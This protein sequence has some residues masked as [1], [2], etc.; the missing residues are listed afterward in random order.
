MT[1]TMNPAMNPT[2]DNRADATQ[3]KAEQ[4]ALNWNSLDQVHA[5]QATPDRD[6]PAPQIRP[7]QPL[8]WPEFWLIALTMVIILATRRLFDS[9]D[10]LFIMLLIGI[11]THALMREMRRQYWPLAL[12]MPATLVLSGWLCA[13]LVYD[14]TLFGGVLPTITTFKE[15]GADL[16]DS[17]FEF[18]FVVAPTEATDGFLLA[19]AIA[20]WAIAASA[21]SLAFRHKGTLSACVPV[22]VLMMFIGA[23]A[24]DGWAALSAGVALF[25]AVLF[26]VTHRLAHANVPW[27]RG[28]SPT[29][30]QAHAPVKLSL[31]LAAMAAVGAILLTPLLPGAQGEAL[32]ALKELDGGASAARVALNPL[33][34]ARGRLVSSSN[35][36][37][38]RVEAD[39]PAYWRV[40][41]LGTFDGF[42]WGSDRSYSD[43]SGQLREIDPN[44]PVLSQV[45]T[46]AALD[47]VWLP[48]AFEPVRFEG[49]N[50]LYDPETATLVLRSG[51]ELET[52]Q[53]YTVVSA[54]GLPTIEQL[55]TADGVLPEE[56]AAYYTALPSDFSTE[57]VSL[58]EEVTA[59]AT[60]A[61][62]QALGLQNFFLNNFTYSLAA[63]SG[64]D[65]DRLQRFLYEERSG[66]CEQFAGS[67]AAMAR[68]IGLPAR[69][70]V[71]FT[72]GELMDGVYVVRGEH[73][74]AWPE[75]WIGDRWVYFEPTPGRGAPG[76]TAYTGIAAQQAVPG[77]PSGVEISED[78]LASIVPEDLG[79]PPSD[80]TG[81]NEDFSGESGT[82]SAGFA[83]RWLLIPL[84][85]L[86]ALV[87]VWL[88]LVPLLARQRRLARHKRARGNHRSEVQSSWLD[89]CEALQVTGMQRSVCESHREFAKRAADISMLDRA[90][91]DEIARTVDYACFAK[92][93]PDKNATTSLNSKV[94]ELTRLVRAQN[95]AFR[96]FRYLYRSGFKQNPGDRR[97]DSV[98][99]AGA[100][101]TSS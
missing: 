43:A 42:V 91:V 67:Y 30:R 47:S 14:Q 72:P 95:S 60:N 4:T 23:L 54:T 7:H 38:F 13:K 64:H 73:Y 19:T 35:V 86:A 1:P 90:T 25:C 55:S 8:W 98:S 76:A 61:F 48:A 32:I 45:V 20:A 56:I 22:F 70:A 65:A 44:E 37:L 15:I 3:T 59:Q 18:G 89:L 79:I 39:A 34:D 78:P 53:S 50:T 24:T 41:A 92:Q 2:V 75:V 66:Y 57:I 94:H 16:S 88:T 40:S 28:G 83:W 36:E 100:A 33:V 51:V 52:E 49:E 11:G 80:L 101:S 31:G 27:L 46:I 62:E 26:T 99:S 6:I 63:T 77:E 87:L 12:A 58:A 5:S 84:V 96:R 21:D 93:A 85:A 69:V 71:G 29:R 17:W 68:S 97:A 10:Y 81:F 9:W 74:H 82:V